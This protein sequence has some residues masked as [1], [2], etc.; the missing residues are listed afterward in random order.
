MCMFVPAMQSLITKH[1]CKHMAGG[2]PLYIRS[3]K[4]FC[5]D[6]KPVHLQSLL[7]NLCKTSLVINHSL[8]E[9]MDC[10]G[11]SDHNELGFP[12]I[13]VSI[14]FK[15]YLYIYRLKDKIHFF[16]PS[17]FLAVTFDQN[18]FLILLL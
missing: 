14:S 12:Q 6:T 2:K 15:V 10:R 9:N 4:R 7:Q 18:G 5:A 13:A 1:T 11:N 8:K 3:Q 17:F 16:F